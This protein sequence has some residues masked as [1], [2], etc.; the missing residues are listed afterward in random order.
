MAAEVCIIGGNVAIFD[1]T[2]PMPQFVHG[3]PNCTQATIDGEHITMQFD[4]GAVHLPL[5]ELEINSTLPN[6]LR[7]IGP[8]NDLYS[9][10]YRGAGNNYYLLET[11]R[12]Y[13]CDI[14]TWDLLYASGGKV[15]P[16]NPE[17]SIIPV[18]LFV[19]IPHGEVFIEARSRVVDYGDYTMHRFNLLRRT[20][21]PQYYI[22]YCADILRHNTM[23]NLEMEMEI[24][25]YLLD[26]KVY[27]ATIIDDKA[28]IQ[29][30]NI[31][32]E[33]TTDLYESEEFHDVMIITEQYEPSTQPTQIGR[34]TVWIEEDHEFWYFNNCKYY[35]LHY[36][37][38][39]DIEYMFILVDNECVAVKFTIAPSG[40][41]TKPALYE[42]I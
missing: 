42:F 39:D 26:D 16:D 23:K 20:Y 22:K 15:E 28:C 10:A 41:M 12:I 29:H 1:D 25:L 14:N 7:M 19:H 30:G 24:S 31:I 3:W 32:R 36:C 27:Y 40:R 8:Y 9:V 2:K 11:N 34:F 13:Y 37:L 21:E 35:K 4:H 17:Y 6:N 18:Q 33:L 5:T 38:K